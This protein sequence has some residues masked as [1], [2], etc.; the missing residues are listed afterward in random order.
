MTQQYEVLRDPYHGVQRLNLYQFDG[1]PMQP[2]YLAFKPPQML[3]TQT[4]NPTTSA[5]NGAKPTG[6]GKTKRALDQLPVPLNRHVLKKRN[7]PVHAHRWWW[8]GAGMTAL[9]GVGYLFF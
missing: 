7:D 9:G 8:V 1:T 5:T 2:M 3:P 6:T 4:M